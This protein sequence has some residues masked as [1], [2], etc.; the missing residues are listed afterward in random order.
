MCYLDNYFLY[1]WYLLSQI[2]IIV[3]INVSSWAH[4]ISR[5]RYFLQGCTSY[6]REISL[7]SLIIFNFL[8][9]GPINRLW[10]RIIIISIIIIIVI[11]YRFSCVRVTC[12]SL[13]HFDV[14]RGSFT[15]ALVMEVE[16]KITP[17]CTVWELNDKE[18]IPSGYFRVINEMIPILIF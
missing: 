9:V 16:M 1:I 10:L 2:N 11:T 4:Q 12:V 15:K 3:I 18:K 8:I 14:W 6:S 17:A 5:D 7:D 13:M